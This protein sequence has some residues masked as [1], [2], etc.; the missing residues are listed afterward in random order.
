MDEE[1]RSVL[2]KVVRFERKKGSVVTHPEA[3]QGYDSPLRQ[4]VP[5]VAGDC[6]DAIGK[7]GEFRS[8]TQGPFQQGALAI[9]EH[10]HQPGLA[11]DITR[12]RNRLALDDS[13]TNQG[14]RQHR[15]R[16]SDSNPDPHMP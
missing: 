11:G 15:H 5:A 9:L 14:K 16:R 7:D 1:E 12:G 2:E 13:L 6:D 10:I 3:I 4:F 8:E